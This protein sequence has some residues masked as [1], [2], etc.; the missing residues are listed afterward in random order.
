MTPSEFRA[1]RHTLGHSSQAMAKALGLSDGRAVRRYEAGDRRISGPI[2]LLVNRMLADHRLHEDR[3]PYQAEP[4]GSD[5]GSTGNVES[6][7]ARSP[8]RGATG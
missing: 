3:E 4:G 2:E 6:R 1:A 5:K 7:K 8:P